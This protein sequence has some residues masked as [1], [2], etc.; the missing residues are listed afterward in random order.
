MQFTVKNIYNFGKK[1][2]PYPRSLT[3]EGTLKT[4]K[5][6]QKIIPN[7]K[8]NNFKCGTKAFDW[9]LP[10]EWIIKD[11]YVLD[12]N[13]KKIINF[14]VNNLHLVSYSKKIDKLMTFNELKKNLYF[15]K[16][17][18]KAIPYT[19]SY[20]EKN[21]GFCLSYENYLKLNRYYSKK[22]NVKKKLRVF[23]DSKFKPHGKMYY[24][25]ILLSGKSKK[26]V[27][28]STNICHPSLVNNEL[29]GLLC[30][31]L[32]YNYFK[33]KNNSRSIRML[34]L[35]ETIG[36]IAYINKNE[37]K[38]KKY[39]YGGYVLSCLADNRSFSYLKT[40]KENTP[41]DKAALSIIKQEKI[42]AKIYSFLKRGSDER[43]YNS[44]GIDLNIGSILRT[45]YR[46]YPEYHTSD[47]N[48]KLCTIK[49]LQ[50]GFEYSKKII[51]LLIENTKPL[52]RVKCEPMLSKRNLYSTIGSNIQN[53]T[54]QS[55]LDVLQFCD[56]KNDII[57]ISEKINLKT[58][59]VINIV[60]KLASHKLISLNAN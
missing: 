40:K 29:S 8:I 9:K 44:V 58:D 12:H 10:P 15:L 38:L 22:K 51:E 25:E 3:G 16:K 11:A 14:K 47:D 23:V 36:A 56:G 53:K 4:L 43:Q 59:D 48:F 55:L 21:W 37:K 52:I 34:F 28:L 35:P 18:P 26:E 42:K 19:T 1:I 57:D 60:K 46:E 27:L 6:I 39:I 49:G 50:G 17:R 33:K 54:Y 20:Y 45:K 2:F 7:L 41:S 31:I 13:K 30:S 5:E 24:G 32:L